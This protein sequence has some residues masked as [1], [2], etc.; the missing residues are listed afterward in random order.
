MTTNRK[1]LAMDPA[2]T[3]AAL[4]ARRGWEKSTDFEAIN[5]AALQ[6]FE[7][8]LARLLP[9]SKR[10]GGELVALNPRRADRHI[11]SFKINCYTGKRSDFATSDKGGDP[12]SLLAYLGSVSQGEAA[13]MLARML[14]IETEGDR[15]G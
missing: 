10:V 3:K 5:R 1:I 13:R 7:V 6:N 2:M 15:R 4:S 12:T 8:V 11:G 14:G 9:G